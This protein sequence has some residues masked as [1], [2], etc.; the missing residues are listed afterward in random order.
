M[1]DF[2]K[3]TRNRSVKKSALALVLVLAFAAVGGG[4]LLRS[5]AAVAP[6]ASGGYYQLTPPGSAFRSEAECA[7]EVKARGNTWEPRY[8]ENNTANHTSP[9]ATYKV[10]GDSA[11]YV[12]IWNSSYNTRVTGNFNGTTDQI[13]QWAACKWGWSDEMIRAEA[14]DESNWV[15]GVGGDK[16]PR[17]NGHCPYDVSGDPC[18]TSYG[19]LQTKWYFHPPGF[20]S[21]DPQ[22]SY[23]WIRTSTAFEV[24]YFAAMMRGCYDG[25]S[26]YLGKTTENGSKLG[27]TKGDAWGCVGSWYSGYW[28]DPDAEPYISRIQNN[29]NNKV[30]LSWPD[31]TP[32]GGGGDTQSPSVSLAS[33]PP[34]A[35][36]GKVSINPTY[37]DNVGVTKIELYVDGKIYAT[38]STSPFSFIWDTSQ[39]SNG[40]HTVQAKAYDAAGNPPGVSAVITYNVQNADTQKP[41]VPTGLS[42]TANS[43]T[44][45]TLNWLKSTDNVGVVGYDISRGTSTGAAQTNIASVDGAVLTFVDKNV[46]AGQTYNYQ[47][48]ARDAAGNL[49]GRSTAVSVTIPSANTDTV[50]PI[51][52][53][54]SPVPDQVVADSININTNATDNIAVVKVEFYLDGILLTSFAPPQAVGPSYSMTWN[55]K[56]TANGYHIIRV[57]ARD[58]A[59]NAGEAKVGINVKNPVQITAP[60]SVTA[61]ASA[62][63]KINITWNKSTVEGSG[64]YVQRAASNGAGTALNFTTI[65]TVNTGVTSYSDTSV[66]ASTTYYYRVVAFDASNNVSIPSA[67]SAAV[68]TPPSPAAALL[69]INSGGPGVGTP[70]KNW[71]ADQ[72]FTG[73]YTYS[74]GAQAIAGTED[75]AIYQT[76]RYGAMTYNIPVANGKYT[77]RLHFAEIYSGCQYVGCRIFN[78]GVNGTPLLSNFDI[79]AKVGGYSATVAQTTATV[80]NGSLNINLTAIKENP[81]LSGIEIIPADISAPTAPTNLVASAVSSTQINLKWNLATDDVGVVKYYV[82]RNSSINP[83]AVVYSSSAGTSNILS[84]GDTTLNASTSYSYNVKAVDAAGNIGPSSATASAT[85]YAAPAT[86]PG[87]LAGNITAA[88]PANPYSCPTQPQLTKKTSSPAKGSTTYICTQRV[89]WSLN[90]IDNAGLLV[91]GWYGNNTCAAVTSFKSK[92]GLPA[93]CI[94]GINAW[95][96]LEKYSAA[97]A[98]APRARVT[99]I[100]SAGGTNNVI[101]DN[102]G[103]YFIP[104]IL[105]GSYNFGYSLTNYAG[106]VINI[107]ITSGQTVQ[108]NV[109]LKH[110]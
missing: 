90:L 74:V 93:D 6:P 7:A 33:A 31:K 48:E 34:N 10:G 16:E 37:S 96:T 87:S 15:Q 23:P 75:D 3:E 2:I 53:I 102:S 85:T 67:V 13:F 63:N 26:T 18:A 69:R 62:Y 24:D 89:Q 43:S 19:I 104:G 76:E 8:A 80:S 14:V 1:S 105:P 73:G 101:A 98:P 20:A 82:Y 5:Y 97:S 83:V 12:D 71:I 41:T 84:W 28:H 107:G 54:A 79:F 108:K 50:L 22:S 56:S 21:N 100:N 30:W 92:Y 110:L 99:Y 68:I 66:Q 60:S 45:V 4:L 25:M 64:Y 46:S 61:V 59:G 91:D 40:T 94:F 103:N 109:I 29:F 58:A 86:T 77:V 36:A 44:Q 81:K 51:V 95:A 52:S 27:D 35:V 70:G 42:A 39:Y 17:S 32:T 106:Q 57:V 9:P 65:A 88:N 49:S 38:S 11:D 78:V 55:P 72:H 47:V